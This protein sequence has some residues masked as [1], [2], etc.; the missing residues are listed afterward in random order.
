MST[1]LDSPA[2]QRWME[3]VAAFL[4]V[5]I[6]S[7]QI[8]ITIA[9]YVGFVVSQGN[10]LTLMAQQ[11]TIIQNVFVAIVAFFFGASVGTR[12]KDEAINTLSSTAA[13][14]QD[15]LAPVPGASQTVPLAAGDAVTVKA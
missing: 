6:A 14:A 13:K 1:P 12:K 15:A 11:Q 9:P 7:T 2:N 8:F 10:D 4:A 3:N 5:S